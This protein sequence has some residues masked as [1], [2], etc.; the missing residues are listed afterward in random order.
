M[1]DPVEKETQP[2]VWPKSIAAITLFVEDLEAAKDFYGRVFGLTVVF[3]LVAGLV[4]F[5]TS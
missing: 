5:T 1:S 2:R 4:F 3:N